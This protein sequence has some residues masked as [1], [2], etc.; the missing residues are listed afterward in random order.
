MER[1][2]NVGK[3]EVFILCNV[4]ARPEL[5][6]CEV[7]SIA[8][9]R[10]SLPNH[11]CLARNHLGTSDIVRDTTWL[12]AKFNGEHDVLSWSCLA[13]RLDYKRCLHQKLWKLIKKICVSSIYSY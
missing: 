11:E 8:W 12:K 10:H 2:S 9:V 4:N 5:F 3:D 7:V 6:R 13:R 1:R